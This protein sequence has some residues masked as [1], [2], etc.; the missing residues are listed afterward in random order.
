MK[1]AAVVFA[2][3]CEEIEGLTAIDVF[4]RLG[5]QAD[6]VGLG[7]RNI[8]GAHNIK[9]D[10]DS[11]ADDYLL[12]DDVVVFPGGVNGANNLKNSDRLMNI[13]QQRQNDGQWNAAMCAAPIAFARYGL[14]NGNDYTCY[15]GFDQQCN[16]D[17]ENAR[18]HEDI[19]VVDPTGHIIT[20]RGPATAMTFALEIAKAIGVDKSGVQKGM[21]YDF[22]KANIN[23]LPKKHANA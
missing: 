14:L 5:M 23:T 20:S 4:R 1:K 15:P 6:M 8:E 3:G 9:L 12:N 7:S 22:L 13:M 11:I 21:L 2:N 10:C 17:A 19:V 16:Q 18:F